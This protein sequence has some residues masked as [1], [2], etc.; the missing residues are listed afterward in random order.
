[1]QQRAPRA[2]SLPKVKF[3]KMTARQY[4]EALATLGYT[5]SSGSEML[6]ISCR[7]SY[8]YARGDTPVPEWQADILTSLVRLQEI[9]PR[10]WPQTKWRR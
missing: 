3:P 6:G 8:H 1:M 4:V 2:K 10:P 7:Q 9:S 5:P